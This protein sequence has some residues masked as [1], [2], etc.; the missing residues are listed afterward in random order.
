MRTDPHLPRLALAGLA[1]IC[2]LPGTAPAAALGAGI[3]LKAFFGPRTPVAPARLDRFL[4]QGSVVVLGVGMDARAVVRA[5]LRGMGFS[6]LLLV[7]TFALGAWLARRL[8]LDRQASLLVSAGTAICGGSAIAAVG[9][10]SRADREAIGLAMGVVFLLN[11][12]ALVA[13][14]AI[15]RFLSLPPD[16]FGTWA[17][18]AVHDVSSVVGAASSFD[19][20]A[21]PAAVATKM[22]R[23]LWIAPVSLVV[24]WTARTKGAHRRLEANL[25]WFLLAFLAAALA[26][27]LAPGL[28]TF[29]PAS[30]GIAH[31]GF[32]LALALIGTRVDLDRIRH[33]GGGL[34]LQGT[35][36]WIAVAAA[37]L[38]A[39]RPR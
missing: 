32:A 37:S 16:V 11:A 7:A 29:A 25:P 22:G 10:S 17:G 1:A 24:A 21:L 9:A 6:L 30:R 38:V 14:P 36:Q 13:F 34:L 2:L 31:A 3:A 23:T 20:R 4:L 8:R 35:L 26:G 28:A 18:L 15:G 12:L 33:G 19:A 5:G 27:T 39:V